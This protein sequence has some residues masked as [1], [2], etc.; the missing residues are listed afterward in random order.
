MNYLKRRESEVMLVLSRV[1]KFSFNNQTQPYTCFLWVSLSFSSLLFRKTILESNC[2]NN[3]NSTDFW[4][5]MSP[6]D[7][8][9]ETNKLQITRNGASVFL[10]K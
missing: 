4:D 2:I 5:V 10:K 7:N 9:E 6:T 8:L 1:M 3:S